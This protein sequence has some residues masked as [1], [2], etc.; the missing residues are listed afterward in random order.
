MSC[1]EKEAAK[2]EICPNCGHEIDEAD[3]VG[4]KL[5]HKNKSAQE[6]EANIEATAIICPNCRVIFFDRFQYAIIQGLREP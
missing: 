3:L 6:I 5:N 2:G 4:I 1:I